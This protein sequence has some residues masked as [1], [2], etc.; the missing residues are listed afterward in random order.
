MLQVILFWGTITIVYFPDN[1]HNWTLCLLRWRTDF[2]ECQL[3]VKSQE[4]PFPRPLTRSDKTTHFEIDQDEKP[5]LYCMLPWCYVSM[6]PLNTQHK[7]LDLEWMFS[8]ICGSQIP[9]V[10][11]D[12]NPKRRSRAQN[13][14]FPCPCCND[15]RTL[16]TGSVLVY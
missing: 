4:A 10:L 1:N 16:W 8:F 9:E 14:Q 15:R 6:C 3:M 2:W 13:I 7:P 5:H 11:H 12:T